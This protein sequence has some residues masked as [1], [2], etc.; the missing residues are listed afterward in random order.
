M[1]STTLQG[2]QP[3]NYFD[4]ASFNGQDPGGTETHTFGEDS[5]SLSREF[6]IGQ[7]AN[8]RQIIVPKIQLNIIEEKSPLNQIRKLQQQSL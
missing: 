5:A 6:E 1:E 4:Y 2:N 7:R 8:H 3:A